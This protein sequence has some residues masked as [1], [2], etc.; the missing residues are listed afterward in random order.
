MA[1]TGTIARLITHGAGTSPL[2]LR[3]TVDSLQIAESL[4]GAGGGF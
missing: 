3:R 4:T 2:E 1:T